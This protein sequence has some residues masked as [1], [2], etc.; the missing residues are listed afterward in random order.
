MRQDQPYSNI[1]GTYVL[2]PQH[3]MQGYE[4]NMFCMSLNKPQNRDKFRLD[5]AAYLDDFP[6][7]K[8]QRK[9]VLSRDWLGLLQLGGNIYY[10][11]KLAIFDRRNMQYV[12]GAMSGVSEQE[13]T[14]MM[15]AGGRPVEGNLYTSEEK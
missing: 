5:E 1:P 2:D 10:T 4:L 8:E 9:A 13:F 14:D 3:S 6:L 12:G 7:T 15:I 11:F